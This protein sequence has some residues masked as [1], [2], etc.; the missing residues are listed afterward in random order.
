MDW[1]SGMAE[2]KEVESRAPT[3]VLGVA[4]QTEDQ[5][6]IWNVLCRFVQ[7]ASEWIESLDEDPSPLWLLTSPSFSESSK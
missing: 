7:T 6:A 4:F 1:G 5:V 3:V 2:S